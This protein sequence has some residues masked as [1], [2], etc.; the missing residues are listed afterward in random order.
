MTTSLTPAITSLARLAAAIEQ[1]VLRHAFLRVDAATASAFS[2]PGRALLLLTDDP[3]RNP[4]V[5]D[6]CVIL[7]EAL[8]G[9]DRSELPTFVADA[10]ASLLL[11]KRFAVARA[12]AVV[13]LLDGQLRGTLPGIR[14]WSEYIA[15]IAQLLDGSRKSTPVSIPVV[16]A[17]QGDAA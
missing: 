8:K 5:L 17:V 4:E 3:Q 10:D 16:R 12:P 14:D 11:M 6:A 9:Q 2:P 13:L 1:L 15:A 7:P